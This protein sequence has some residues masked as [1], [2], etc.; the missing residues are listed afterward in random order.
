MGGS[1]EWSD[2]PASSCSVRG[3]DPEPLLV[4][5]AKRSLAL[6]GAIAVSG[7]PGEGCRVP[8]TSCCRVLPAS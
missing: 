5:G 2:L 6:N 7:R 8:M 3:A 1:S 4:A